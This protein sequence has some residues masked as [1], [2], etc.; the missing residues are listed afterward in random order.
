VKIVGRGTSTGRKEWAVRSVARLL[1]LLEEKDP[2]REEFCAAARRIYRE[3]FPKGCRA[4][5][6]YFPEFLGAGDD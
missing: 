5:L 6:C 1:R 2:G 4:T 3:R